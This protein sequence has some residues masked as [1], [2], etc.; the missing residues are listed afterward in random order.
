[1]TR[2]YYKLGELRKEI[3]RGSEQADRGEFVNGP[4]AFRQIRQRRPARR[5]A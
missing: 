3:M 4:E 2:W 1:M 5:T